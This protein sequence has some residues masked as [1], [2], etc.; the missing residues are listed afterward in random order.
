MLLSHT[1]RSYVANRSKFKCWHAFCENSKIN[2]MK[3]GL[4]T[5]LGT[6]AR[7]HLGY[8][9]VSIASEGAL[10]LLEA[11]HRGAGAEIGMKLATYYY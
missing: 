7:A 6:R 2:A 10:L 11:W 8:K 1:L 9:A 5:T 3:H 4:D